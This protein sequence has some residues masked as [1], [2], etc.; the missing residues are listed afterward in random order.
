[1]ATLARS[2]QMSETQQMCLQQCRP[3]GFPYAVLFQ[4][5]FDLFELSRQPMA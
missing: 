4:Y 1:M 2:G 3:N 5:L